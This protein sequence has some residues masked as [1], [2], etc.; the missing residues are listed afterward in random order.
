M[1]VIG[2]AAL[3]VL[4]LR[5]T[6]WKTKLAERQL[7]S[8]E[9]V[10]EEIITR[11]EAAIAKAAEDAKIAEEKQRIKALRAENR[12]KKTELEAEEKNADSDQDMDA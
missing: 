4:V 9:K 12:K 11:E 10:A 8:D 1:A 3:V 6:I 2:V 7:R 5:H